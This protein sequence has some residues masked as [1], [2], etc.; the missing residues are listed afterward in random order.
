M[1]KSGYLVLSRK[2]GEG[3]MIG[4]H[5]VRISAVYRG[6]PGESNAVFIDLAVRAPKEVKISK[7]ES[8]LKK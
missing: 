1:K 5:E 7:L 2:V 4:E 6:K 8:R 3:I